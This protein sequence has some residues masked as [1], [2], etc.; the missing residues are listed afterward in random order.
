MR[1]IPVT[2]PLIETADQHLTIISHTSST[3]LTPPIETENAIAMP[4]IIAHRLQDMTRIVL[5]NMIDPPPPQHQMPAVAG[6][7]PAPPA[8]AVVVDHQ[9][10]QLHQVV[11][12]PQTTIVVV[13]D[14][15]VEAHQHNRPM[16]GH[17]TITVIDIAMGIEQNM[18]VDLKILKALYQV[19]VHQVLAQTLQVAMF[20]LW[21][22]ICMVDLSLLYHIQQVQKMIKVVSINVIFLYILGLLLVNNKSQYYFTSQYRTMYTLLLY[23]CL[24]TF[25]KA[26]VLFCLSAMLWRLT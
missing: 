3:V 14:M 15:L 4:H 26:L 8:V 23:D 7:Y 18:I 2:P 11:E 12:I 25:I 22:Q 1:S 19:L 9:Q 24:S 10:T 16:D 13:M 6:H 20:Y 5:G 17:N 21:L